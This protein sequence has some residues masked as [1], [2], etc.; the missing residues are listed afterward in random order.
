MND[1][2]TFG[3]LFWH[4]YAPQEHE[5]KLNFNKKNMPSNTPCPRILKEGPVIDKYRLCRTYIC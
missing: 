3:Q 4:A 1:F 2:K 5:N